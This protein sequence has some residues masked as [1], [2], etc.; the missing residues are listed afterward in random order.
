[1]GKRGLVAGGYWTERKRV[2]VVLSGYL[3]RDE[4]PQKG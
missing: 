1:M 3:V 4:S 2:F